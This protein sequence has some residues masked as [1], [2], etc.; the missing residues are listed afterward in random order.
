MYTTT[1]VNLITVSLAGLA[2]AAPAA[3]AAPAPAPVDLEARSEFRAAC[4][5]HKEGL[6]DTYGVQGRGIEGVGKWGEHLRNQLK[7][8]GAYS[9]WKFEYNKNV[10]PKGDW[11]E[12]KANFVLPVFQ[13]ACVGQAVS[14]VAGR[15][16]SCDRYGR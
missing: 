3:P 8:C 13:F 7:G 6:F 15:G 9:S 4:S 10:D 11:Y 16:V 1:I 5:W 2:A 14:V 12:W